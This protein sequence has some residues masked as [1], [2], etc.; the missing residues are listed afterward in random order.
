MKRQYR[1][2][3]EPMLIEYLNKTYPPGSWRT[4]VRLGRPSPEL[5][6]MAMT[7]AER[8]MLS[9]TTFMADA[10]VTLP[11]RVDIVEILV[12]PEWW[13]VSQLKVYGHLF[14][15]TEEYRPHWHKPRRL[16]MVA[17]VTN[18]FLEWWARTEGVTWILYRPIW[19]DEYEA[20][21]AARAMAG[22]SVRLPTGEEKP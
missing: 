5:E 15:T 14:G 11:D 20:T 12:R 21:T 13:K 22:P 3:H 9:I 7:P 17:A 18:E 16:I 1:V 10:V 2:V 6:A 4:N 8:R 19:V